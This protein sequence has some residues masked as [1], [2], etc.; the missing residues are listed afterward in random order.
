MKRELLIHG[1][2]SLKKLELIKKLDTDFDKFYIFTRNIK[3]AKANLKTYSQK[4]IFFEN[5][6]DDFSITLNDLKKLPNSINSI[7]WVSG[8]TGNAEKEFQSIDDCLKTLNV[9]FVNVILSINFLLKEK[10]LINSSSFICCLTSVAGLRGR[11]FNT[12]YGSAKS[13]LISYLS[14]LRQKY[15]NQ[16][17]IVTV[18]P[19]Y[20]KT[21]SFDT[22]SNNLIVSSPKKSA[23]IIYNAIKKKKEIVYVDYKW[24]FI[25]SLVRL[26]PEKI[27]KKLNF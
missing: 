10:F 18:I 23:D 20:M 24:K 9:N 13:G 27:F 3:L 7:L 26:I 5:T 19:G 4:I 12:F 1:G 11:K 22:N 2:S 14:S 21:N 17:S 6:L 15:D 16:I 8:N 25:M